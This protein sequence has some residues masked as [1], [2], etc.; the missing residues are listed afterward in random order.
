MR[1]IVKPEEIDDLGAK[2]IAAEVATKI[3]GDSEFP[4]QV[5]V[6][7]VREFRATKIAK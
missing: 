7:V 3:E 1:L 4:G 6:T 2:R 5:K